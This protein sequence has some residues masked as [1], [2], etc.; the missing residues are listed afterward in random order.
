GTIFFISVGILSGIHGS[1]LPSFLLLLLLIAFLLSA[2]PL[3]R[4][5]FRSNSEALIMAFPIG[6]ILH[7]VLLAF[8]AIC[9]GINR[10]T[11]LVYLIATAAAAVAYNSYQRKT[12]PQIQS[13]QDWQSVDVALLF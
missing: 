2:L 12:K 6:F 10:S 13:E 8:C 9:F 1:L 11:I 3:S 7:T 5:L 4:L